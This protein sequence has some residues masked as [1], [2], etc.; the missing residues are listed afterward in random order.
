MSP[1]EVERDGTMKHN[2]NGQVI[3]SRPASEQFSTKCC[4]RCGG[5]LVTEWC[6]DLH[7]PGAHR[8][9]AF[10]CVQCGYCI[11]PVILQNQI[12]SP[13]E[14]RPRRQVWPMHSQVNTVLW[15][16]VA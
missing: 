4:A 1:K 5:L 6:Y 10:R 3:P 13:V 9:E 14:R 2:G 12:Q 7:N 8:V 11:D 15:D 16:E